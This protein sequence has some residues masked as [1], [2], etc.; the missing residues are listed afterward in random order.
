MHLLAKKLALD[1]NKDI[2]IKIGLWVEDRDVVP[3][4]V[5]APR[6]GVDYAGPVWSKKPYRFILCDRIF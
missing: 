4:V 6:I 5:Q 1:R 3:C 2:E